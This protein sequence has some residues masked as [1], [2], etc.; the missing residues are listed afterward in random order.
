MEHCIRCK[1]S[2]NEAR[3]YDAIYDGRA[4]LIC[5]RCAIIENIPI[6]DVNDSKPLQ[7][8]PLSVFERMKRISGIKEEKHQETFVL[9]ERLSHVNEHPVEKKIQLIDNFHWDIMRSRRRKGLTQE[10]FA[11]KIGESSYAIERVERGELPKDYEELIRKIEQFLDIRLRK[12]SR[13]E[14]IEKQEHHSPVLLD[15]QG[16]VLDRIPEPE[17]I[18]PPK[19]E[20]EEIKE[21]TFP[22]KI[23]I[24]P[25]Y[26]D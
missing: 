8:K 5:E 1:I 18:L 2:E 10:Q 25:N 14:Q 24:A 13:F 23:T 22:K 11:N 21:K 17:I 26:D 20:I 15:E 12:I 16:N 6:L 4:G 9:K 3:L 19:P 7:E